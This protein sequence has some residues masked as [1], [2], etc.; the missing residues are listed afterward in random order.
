MAEF[1]ITLGGQADYGT[2]SGTDAADA[3]LACLRD[4]DRT[5]EYGTPRLLSTSP[6]FGIGARTQDGSGN[7][8][9][10]RSGWWYVRTATG[11]F[12]GV[13]E[14]DEARAGA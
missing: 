9:A 12:V 4:A 13:Y 2:F 1:Q 3:V 7:G 5:R 14:V 10:D 6:T 8:A 11:E